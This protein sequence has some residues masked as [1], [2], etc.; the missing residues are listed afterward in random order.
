MYSYRIRISFV[1]YEMPQASANKTGFNI[2]IVHF[3]I[4]RKLDIIRSYLTDINRFRSYTG[5][6]KIP[7]TTSFPEEGFS[8][9]L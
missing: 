5:N 1:I 9:Y 2:I 4:R 3:Y 6:V 7:V 8:L